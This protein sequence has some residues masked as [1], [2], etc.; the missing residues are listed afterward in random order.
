M[1]PYNFIIFEIAN[2][3]TEINIYIV[4]K[5]IIVARVLSTRVNE[6]FD[7]LLEL[8]N[9]FSESSPLHCRRV[10]HFSNDAELQDFLITRLKFQGR[11]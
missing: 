10:S 7:W 9:G 3:Q 6:P 2:K 4:N 11:S 8:Y 5:I 1:L